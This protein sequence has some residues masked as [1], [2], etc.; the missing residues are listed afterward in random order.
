M[1]FKKTLTALGVIAL[2]FVFL[3]PYY[4]FPDGQGYFAYLPSLFFDRDLNLFNNFTEMRVP[5]PLALTPTGHI[6]NYWSFGTAFFWSPFYFL[7]KQ[8]A[9]PSFSPYGSWYWLWVNFG[10]VC[11]G[12]MTLYLLTLLPGLAELKEKRPALLAWAAVLGTPAF[13]YTYTICATAHGITAFTGTVFVW[14]WLR[15]MDEWKKVSRYVLLGI[16]LGLAAMVRPQEALFGTAV[17]GEFA[18]R[19]VKNREY[20][21]W[22]RPFIMS[23]AGFLAGLSPQLFAW[24]IIYGNY[25]ASPAKFNVALKY[26][27]PWQTLFSSFHGLLPW[28]PL[29][30]AAF[31]GIIIGLRRKPG[32]Y[33]GLLLVF[34]GQFLTN[35]CM[36]GFWEGYSFGLRQMTSLLPVVMLGSAELV[37]AFRGRKGWTRYTG[38]ALVALPALWTAGLLANTYLGLDLLGYLSLRD[39]LHWQRTLPARLPELA[40]KLYGA[41]RP[42]FAN[43]LLMAAC[44]AAF[45]WAGYTLK[46]FI[47]KKKAFIA[48]AALLSAVLVFNIIVMKAG[49]V[50]V[51]V[52]KEQTVTEEDLQKFFEGQFKMIKDKYGISQ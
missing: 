21:S 24:K 30:F 41:Q 20:A 28:T 18:V 33:L 23:A 31:A 51:S 40:A 49:S 7:A 48:T 1:K 43:F 46:K 10:T 4:L 3:N 38:W 45:L 44:G 17:I 39:L 36:I 25:F 37:N 9:Y 2:A 19:I 32:I 35:A 8:L 47:D 52:P 5:M 50:N 34:L 29:Y 27:S 13:F 6:S 15:S 12:L 26:F 22:I 14:Y 11:Y 42:D 16:L